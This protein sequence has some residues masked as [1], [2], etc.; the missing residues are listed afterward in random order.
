MLFQSPEGSATKPPNRTESI[1]M[2]PVSERGLEGGEGGQEGEIDTH[3]KPGGLFYDVY[4]D[5]IPQEQAESVCAFVSPNH[6]PEPPTSLPNT[7]SNNDKNS[8]EKSTNKD[9]EKEKDKE[10][11]GAV[12]LLNPS[13]FLSPVRTSSAGDIDCE[14]RARLQVRSQLFK[15]IFIY[16]ISIFTLYFVSFKR[17]F[18]F[19]MFQLCH[20]N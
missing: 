7:T 13:A 15:I 2:G 9:S 6:G 19:S 12:A 3:T 20:T 10:S 16:F 1:Y 14:L 18:G 11:S 8:E 17:F 5:L 4:V